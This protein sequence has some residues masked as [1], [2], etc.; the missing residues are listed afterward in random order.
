MKK[1]VIISCFDWYEKRL[2]YLAERLKCQNYDVTVFTSDFD[3]IKKERIS[4]RIE[5]VTYLKTPQYTSNVSARR[6]FSH[7]QF[8]RYCY[9][10]LKRIK[11]DFIYSL[12]PPNSICRY[13]NKYKNNNCCV[14]IYDIID[15][16]PESFPSRILRKTPLFGIWKNLR[17]CGLDKAD[18]IVVECDYY[19]DEIGRNYSEKTR[20]LKLFKPLVANSISNFSNDLSK[21]SSQIADG[22]ISLCYLGSI[23]N[24][25]DIEAIRT[26]V[27]SLIDNHFTVVFHVI[28]DGSSREEF[29]K[30]LESTGCDV[31]YHGKVFDD[32]VKQ[33]ILGKCDFGINMMKESVKVGLTLKSIDYFING[34]PIINSIKGDTWKFVTNN[35]VGINYDSNTDRLISRIKNT[36]ISQLKVNAFECY[37]NNFSREKFEKDFDTILDDI[38]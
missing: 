1:A 17:D 30:M 5:G 27:Q 32:A 6:I 10:E 22:Q 2:Y 33:S 16:W 7:I 28:G 31:V 21:Y 13:V 24:I 36:N 9:I 35:D 29:I 4:D 14:L 37:L 3:H 18:R 19:L 12:I 23:N 8:A 38:V 15:L 25:I 20:T 11:P 34:L 26:I